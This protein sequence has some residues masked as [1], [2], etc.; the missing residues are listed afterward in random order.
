MSEDLIHLVRLGARPSVT[1]CG[2]TA[3]G[4]CRGSIAVDVYKQKPTLPYVVMPLILVSYPK[5]WE[6]G[7]AICLG[8]RPGLDEKQPN[9]AGMKP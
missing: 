3:A 7:D 8:C 5:G 9:F 6:E 4:T 2:L 1:R